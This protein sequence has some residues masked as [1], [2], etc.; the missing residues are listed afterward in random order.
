MIRA[1]LWV[2]A[3]VAVVTVIYAGV[4]AIKQ[5]GAAAV[6]AKVEAQKRAAIEAAAGR[7]AATQAKL[8]EKARRAEAQAAA[9]AQELKGLRDVAGETGKDFIVFGNDWG[10]WL[11]GKS[12]AKPRQ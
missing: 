3:F 7:S 11:R 10:E 6:V 12:G 4:E 1:F 8:A 5:A 9:R 2:L